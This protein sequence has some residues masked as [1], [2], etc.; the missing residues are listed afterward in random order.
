MHEAISQARLLP[1]PNII[2]ASILT[3][4]RSGYWSQKVSTVPRQYSSHEVSPAATLMQPQ[5]LLKVMLS[6]EDEG[7]PASAE[8]E[9]GP[10][11][12]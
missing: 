9:R 6:A 2:L 7:Y 4:K 10:G 3:V 8:Q 5:R 1:V 11:L 12:K